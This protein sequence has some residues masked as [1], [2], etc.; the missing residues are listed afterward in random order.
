MNLRKEIRIF[1]TALMFLTRLPVPRFTD[2]SPEYLEKSSKYF[3]LIGWIV[4]S[5]SAAVLLLF[6][7]VVSLDLSILA[8][9]I[10]SILT[11]GAFH[12]D[13]FADVCDAFGGGWTMEKILEIMKDSRL[14]TYGTTG[15]IFILS[16]KFLLLRELMPAII[17]HTPSYYLPVFASMLAAH[18]ASRFMSVCSIQF[19]PYVTPDDVSKSKPSAAHKLPGVAF[20]IAFLFAI[21]PFVFLPVSFLLVFPALF[22]ATFLLNRY[23]QKWIGGHTGDCLGTVQQS[24]ELLCYLTMLLL[25]KFT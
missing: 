5:I 25:W 2:H 8:L 3:P 1:F 18:A 19:Y 13:G 15:L 23:F 22:L 16:A 6:M 21:I 10:A 20:L 4:G 9:M 17:H 7:Q 11:T 12:E 14:G 24:C